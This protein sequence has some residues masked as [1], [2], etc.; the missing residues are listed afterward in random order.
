MPQSKYKHVTR[1]ARQDKPWQ[2]SV[3]GEY[4]GTFADEEQAAEVVAKKLR[5]PKAT[6]LRKTAVGAS[7]RVPKRIPKRAHR[8]IY[9]HHRAQAWQVKIGTAFLGVFRD[10]EDALQTVIE[11]K[12]L[13]REELR[14]CPNAVRRSL[15]GQRNA[16]ML[17]VSWFQSLYTAY[18]IPEAAYPGDLCDMDLRATQGSSILAHPNPIVP[19]MLAKFGPH[20]E[21]LNDAFLH[22]PKPKHDPLDWN[23]PMASSWQLWLS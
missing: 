18:S 3:L 22:T 15:Q 8:Y 13:L 4:L 5:R 17:H 2:A 14:L 11:H 23:G 10:H 9:W 12:G 1:R 21:A 7:S 20:R 16:A 6:L 19:M